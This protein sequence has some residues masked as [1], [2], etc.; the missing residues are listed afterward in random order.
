[1]QLKTI[2][3]GKGGIVKSVRRLAVIVFFLGV[4]III[5]LAKIYKIKAN[6]TE[7]HREVAELKRQV[8]KECK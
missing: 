4:F 1:M 6:Y 5:G 8:M 2:L 7:L 3:A